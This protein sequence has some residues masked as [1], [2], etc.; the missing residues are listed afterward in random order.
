MKWKIKIAP[1]IH[2]ESNHISFNSDRVAPRR[3]DAEAANDLS[4]LK[5]T[6]QPDIAKNEITIIILR[7]TLERLDIHVMYDYLV[8]LFLWRFLNHK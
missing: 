6:T 3:G 4:R 8:G 5:T 1:I 7:P 2:S